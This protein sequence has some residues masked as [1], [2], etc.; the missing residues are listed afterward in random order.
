[1]TTAHAGN[2]WLAGVGALGALAGLGALGAGCGGGAGDGTSPETGDSELAASRWGAITQ[3]E[4]T[5]KAEDGS[6][7]GFD[8]DGEVT[9]A[10]TGGPCPFTDRSDESGRQGID[11]QLA[12]LTPILEQFVGGAVDGLIQGA[13]NEGRLLLLFELSEAPARL[14]IR[15]GEGKPYLGTDGVILDGQTFALADEPPLVDTSDVTVDEAGQ[16]NAATEELTLP[17][18]ILREEFDL[19]LRDVR[20]RLTPTTDGGWQ[21]HLGGGFPVDTIVDVAYRASPYEGERMEGPMRALA[22]LLPL[23]GA[24]TRMSAALAVHAVP[25]YVFADPDD[26]EAD[27]S[28]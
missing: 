11:N 7:P 1:M 23:D 10:G 5:R 17:V 3:I 25:A 21:G 13:V 8:L 20:V 12:E 22:D 14:T 24:C 18:S 28:K 4:L 9:P 27:T 2:C 26:P 15:R 6:V 16:V 19:N